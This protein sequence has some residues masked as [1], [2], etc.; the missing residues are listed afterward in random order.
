M[1]AET[2]TWLTEDELI[3]DRLES[4]HR[5]RVEMIAGDKLPFKIRNEGRLV[6]HLM[7]E[8]TARQRRRIPGVD[9]KRHGQKLAFPGNLNPSHRLNADGLLVGDGYDTWRAYYQMFNDGRLEAVISDTCY[10]IQQGPRVLRDLDCENGMIHIVESYQIVAKELNLSSPFWLF[11]ALTNCEGVRI[12]LNNWQ[13]YSNH[14]ID[15]P[16]IHL[17]GI[18]LSGFDVDA[19]TFLRPV[20]DA[21]W[22]AAGF[23]VSPHYDEAGNRKEIRR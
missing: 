1:I 4:F 23:E 3:F 8:E 18:A 20:F 7:P 16:T 19:K 15:R 21:M 12:R 17:P 10:Q 5:H 14:A 6:V 9:L 13:D 22:N 2:R 11:A